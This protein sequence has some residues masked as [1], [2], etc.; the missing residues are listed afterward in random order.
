[1]IF[2]DAVVPRSMGSSQAVRSVEEMRLN[3]RKMTPKRRK[4]MAYRASGVEKMR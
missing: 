2:C 4:N 1:M 3:C